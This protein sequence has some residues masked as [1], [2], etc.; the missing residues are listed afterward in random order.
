M[1]LYVP[2]GEKTIRHVYKSKHNLTRENQVML[3]M[4]TDGEKWYYLTVRSL[5]T[6]LKIIISNQDG[7]F[8]CLNYF[9]FYRTKKALKST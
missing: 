4:F 5:S 9:Y 2:E 1:F 6:L 8:Y 3:L 7:D